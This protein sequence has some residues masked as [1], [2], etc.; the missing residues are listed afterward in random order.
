MLLT[1]TLALMMNLAPGSAAPLPQV[2]PAAFAC[3]SASE[4]RTLIA[5]HR[6]A[7]PMSALR[8]MARRSKAEPLRSRLC[9]WDDRFVYEM[10]LLR[11]DGKVVRVH[12]DARDGRTV[13]GPPR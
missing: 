5:R 6:L 8:A 4:A 1:F 11:R 9:R 12:V 2:H 10:A 13:V 3:L 7:N